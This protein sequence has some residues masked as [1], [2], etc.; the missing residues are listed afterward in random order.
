M[1][2]STRR[3]GRAT[4]GQHSKLQEEEVAAPTPPKRANSTKKSKKNEPTPPP[5]DE[6]PAIIRCICG[7]VEEDED[8]ERKMICCEEC[9]AWQHNE[10]MEMSENDD[11]LPDKYY[12]EQCRPKNH[13]ELLAKIARGE[14]PWEERAKQ[15]EEEEAQKKSRKKKGKKG[16]KRGRPSEIQKEESQENGIMDTTIDDT[17]DTAMDVVPKQVEAEPPTEIVQTPTEVESNNK[18]KFPEEVIPEAQS[19]SQA[20]PPHKTRKTSTPAVDKPSLP[21]PSRRKSGAPAATK[22]DSTGIQLQTE[23]VEN[24]SDLQSEDRKRVA[25]AIVKLFVGQTKEAEKDGSFRLPPG[26]KADAFGLRLGLAVEYAVYLNFWGQAGKP[27]AQY[28]DKFRAILHNVKAN[29]Q[30]RNDLLS[31]S[32]SPNDFSK[33]SSTDMATKELQVKKAEMLKESEKQHVLIQEE[34][35]RMR[36]THKGEELIED[37]S[38]MADTADAAFTAP[39]MRKRPS[40]IDT[41]IKQASPEAPT[42]QSPAAVELPETFGA[43]SPI[44][45]Q[46]LTVDTSAPP[47]ASAG[48][49][50]KS[51]NNFNIQDV[52]SGVK[53]PD[54][55][56][57]QAP[58][59]SESAITPIQQTPGPGVKA[60][61]EIDQL[62][63]DEEPEDEEPYSP[64]EYTQE[65]GAPIWHGKV[66]M[67]GIASFNGIGKYVAGADLSA[68]LPWHTLVPPALTI[69]GRIDIDRAS[70]YLCGLRWSNTTDVVVVSVT[71]N[72]DPDNVVQFD[73]L[74]RYFTERKRYGVVNKSAVAAVKDTY[75]VP[76]DA[77]MSKKADF[78]E[79]LEYCIIEDP[80]PERMLLLT[81]VVK[82]N[83]SPSAQQTPRPL[84]ASSIASPVGANHSAGPLGSHPGFQDSSIPGMPPNAPLPSH[85]HRGYANGPSHQA[86]NAYI[87]SHQPGYPVTGR[88]AARQVLGEW[89]DA[90]VVSELLAEAPN[91]GVAEFEVIRGMFESVPIT[92]TDLNM[93]KQML[94]IRHQQAQQAEMNGIPQ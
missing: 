15:R 19:P 38:H 56:A 52:W 86:Q 93:L 64:A 5:E 1:A 80:T 47:R 77:G 73:K 79:L 39:A 67:A 88:D 40:E 51:S 34:G 13:K 61:A 37:D 68:Q 48:P 16:G 20:E 76:L 71:P 33:M 12:C 83:N 32:L 87:P 26:Q 44:T 23:L 8:D 42:P 49:E 78:V 84:D 7:Y 62:L 75:I 46:P 72:E 3:S 10:C 60:D 70:E 29:K 66:S 55:G 17:V 50:R 18:R 74:F 91:S 30:L 57:R 22:R 28:S 45:N 21:P 31:G 63:K 6:G 92:R 85:H 11:E 14:K 58:R 82:S 36:R 90:P 81:F 59:P 69:E 35:P 54:P 4:K 53:G 25:G 43:G 41:P 27:S 2:D 65:P 94:E 24:I 9:E 89:A